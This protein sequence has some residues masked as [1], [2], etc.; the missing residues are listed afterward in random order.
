MINVVLNPVY[1]T[2][3]SKGIQDEI[4]YLS[5]NCLAQEVVVLHGSDGKVII[6]KYDKLS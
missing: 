5:L 4:L 1:K 3:F 2:L 6:H